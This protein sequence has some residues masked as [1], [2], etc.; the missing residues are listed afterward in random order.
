M[1]RADVAAVIL[2]TGATLYAIFG[3]ADFGA[4]NLLRFA[5]SREHRGVPVIGGKPREGA[6]LGLPIGDVGR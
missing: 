1:T 5:R 2:W 3:G 6:A 4:G